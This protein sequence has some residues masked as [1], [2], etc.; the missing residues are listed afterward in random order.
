MSPLD[1]LGLD[2]NA[3]AEWLAFERELDRIEAEDAAYFEARD[4]AIAELTKAR[5]SWDEFCAALR[6][7]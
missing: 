1:Y 6:A 4:K 2:D 3:P 7:V 5:T